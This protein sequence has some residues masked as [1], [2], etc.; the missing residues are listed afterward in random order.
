VKVV[1]VAGALL[2]AMIRLASSEGSQDLTNVRRSVIKTSSMSPVSAADRY[3]KVGPLTLASR[4]EI[5][6]L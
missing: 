6:I 1:L 2:S 5:I 3:C 4:G